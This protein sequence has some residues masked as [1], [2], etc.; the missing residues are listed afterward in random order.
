MWITSTYTTK[1]SK[2]GL[3]WIERKNVSRSKLKSQVKEFF[4]TIW[5]NQIDKEEKPRTY[6]IFRVNFGFENCLSLDH[7]R[8]L[9]KL[10]VGTYSLKKTT[11]R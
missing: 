5:E 11:G 2:Y 4:L 8:S 7:W 3:R 6:I 1:F 10:R 9:T